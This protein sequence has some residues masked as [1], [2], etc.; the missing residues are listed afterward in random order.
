MSPLKVSKKS[1]L[2]TLR[3][4]KGNFK[5]EQKILLTEWNV[6]TNKFRKNWSFER[7]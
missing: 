3:L 5:K 4:T 6:G 2:V 7:S 1:Q